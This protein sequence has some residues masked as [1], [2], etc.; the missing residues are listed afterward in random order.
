MTLG[1]PEITPLA[2][3]IPLGKL[4]CTAQVA[5]FPPVFDMV[6]VAIAVPLVRVISDIAPKTA[7]GSLMVSWKVALL[8]PPVLFA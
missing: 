8:D 6:I 3:V 2:R 5:T 7:T 4:G 1:V